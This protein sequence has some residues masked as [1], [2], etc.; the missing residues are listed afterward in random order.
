MAMKIHPS[1]LFKA[2]V[3]DDC[4]CDCDDDGYDDYDYGY[5][6]DDDNN[7]DDGDDDD[8]GDSFAL[9]RAVY[10]KISRAALLH[11]RPLMSRTHYNA[12]ASDGADAA[13][14]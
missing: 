11:A 9:R 13:V 8:D 5:G 7:D 3:L 12:F 4:D 2:K 10:C 1:F 6:D 14:G